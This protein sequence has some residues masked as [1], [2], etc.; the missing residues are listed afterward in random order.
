LASISKP[1]AVPKPNYVL[2]NDVRYKRIWRFY[3][4]LLRQEDE[5]DRLWDWQARTWADISRML[6]NAAL[7][8]LRGETS[9]RVGYRFEESLAS[10]FEIL[11]EQRLGR[12]IEQGSEPGPFLVRPP[13]G[14]TGKDVAL[15]VVHPDL[16]EEHRVTRHFGRMGGHLYLV[17]SPLDGSR[18]T[19]VVV[20]A[21]HTAACTPSARPPWQTIADSAAVALNRH[22]VF[23]SDRAQGF[24]HLYAFVVASDMDALEP[25]LFTSSEGNVHLV[26]IPTNQQ[27][28]AES[29]EWIALVIEEV[30]GELV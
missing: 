1:P 5:E 30:L 12:R 19:V 22:S 6:V 11:S 3:L 29:V 13:R 16:A 27:L 26:E 4:K 8:A 23:L 14:M 10:V 7:M 20:W 18:Q 25:D 21:V 24:P 2:Q 9:G 17:F 28:W 15:E